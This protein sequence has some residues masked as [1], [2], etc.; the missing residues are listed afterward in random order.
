MAPHDLRRPFKRPAI[1]DQERRRQHSLLRQAQNR[2]DAQR[3]ARFLASTVFSLS[4]QTPDSSEIELDLVPEPENQPEPSHKELDVLEASKLK[5]SEAR[6]WFSKQLMHP[7]WMIDIPDSLSP[8]WFVFARPS[9]KR[10]FVVSCNGTTISRL[11][12]GSVLHRFPSALPSGARKKDSGSSQSYS[13]LDCIFH[14]LDQTYYVIDMVCW[15]DYSLYDC[16]AEFR[17]FWLNSKVAESGACDPPSHY[18]K[19]RFSLVPV[20]SCDRDGLYAAYTAPVPYVKDGL[21]FYNKHAH[22]QAGI[23]PLVLVWKDENCS[24]YVMDTDSKGQVPN[25]QQVVLELQEDGKLTTSD[26]PPVVFGCLDGSFTQQS[27]LL[28][29]C[30]LRFAIGEAGLVLVDGK[31]E[32]ADLNYLGKVN[33]AR[34]SADSFS[35]V[36][37]QYSVR[38]SPLRIDDL[39]G[40]VSSPVDEESKPCDI[41]MDG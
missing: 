30:L 21:L 27:E 10:C 40:S 15:R 25:Q 37:F 16:T 5:G 28:S 12:N 33:R 13:I 14:E 38:H 32:K 35:K 9:G 34:A 2:L 41:E 26:D 31:L 1:S 17:F 6:K 39:L 18:H 4:S 36:M 8:N 22:Y 24:Q 11:R 3:H 7:E 20:Y 29:G 19:Y 23:T